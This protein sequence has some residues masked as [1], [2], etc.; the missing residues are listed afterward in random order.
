MPTNDWQHASTWKHTR[1]TDKHIPDH[2]TNNWLLTWRSTW[3]GL[4][5]P[6]A[7]D[8]DRLSLADMTRSKRGT[9]VHNL[10]MICNLHQNQETN[11]HTSCKIIHNRSGSLSL[12]TCAVET[13]RFT[14]IQT[15]KTTNP[16]QSEKNNQKQRNK[17][18]NTCTQVRE[19]STHVQTVHQHSDNTQVPAKVWSVRVWIV[20]PLDLRFPGYKVTRVSGILLYSKWPVVVWWCGSSKLICYR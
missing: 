1:K 4:V 17:K 19:Y 7:V 6:R 9:S 5:N 14:S 16:W 20:R 13:P 12:V 2:A 18:W 8:I 10:C 3:L 15:G 11:T